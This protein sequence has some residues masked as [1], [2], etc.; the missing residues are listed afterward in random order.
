[1]VIMNHTVSIILILVQ[2]IISDSVELYKLPQNRLQM[3]LVVL[4]S[5]IVRAKEYLTKYNSVSEIQTDPKHNK[6]LTAFYNE[7]LL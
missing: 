1:M 5:V 4:H 6:L 2:N 7:F 3:E